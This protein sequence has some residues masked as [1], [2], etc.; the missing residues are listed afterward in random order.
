MPKG[1]G[2][3]RKK[4]KRK[5]VSITLPI[6]PLSTN[7]LFSGRKRRSFHYK[8]YRRK[9]FELMDDI[10]PSLYCF[11]GDLLLVLE[12]GFSSKASDLDNSFKGL[13]DILSEKLAF[14][15]KQL[16]EIRAKKYLVHRG[17]EF[18]KITLKKSNRK[19]INLRGK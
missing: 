14:N 15:D 6:K 3:P 19:D 18:V 13:I 4:N 7:Q 16:C 11:K 2:S 17:D 9:M 5:S 8:R 1:R 10:D 12:V